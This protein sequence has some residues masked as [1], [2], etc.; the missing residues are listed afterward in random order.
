MELSILA[1]Y[2]DKTIPLFESEDCQ[3]LLQIYEDYYP[4]VGFLEPWVAYLIIQEN[5]VVGTCS[6]V[7]PP[8]DNQV[9]IAYWT[10]KEFEGQGIA[11]F[12]CKE[13]IKIAQNTAP[14]ITIIAKTAPEHNASTKILQH[15]QFSFTDT[16]QDDEIGDAWLWT[17]MPAEK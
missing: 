15:N 8:K 1:Q 16:V 9:E 13:L 3:T 4:K 10:F 14:T 7:S 11:S 17:L 2:T 6:F 12:A 5:K